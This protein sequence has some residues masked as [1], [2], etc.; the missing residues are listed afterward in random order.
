M[1]ILRLV[2]TALLIWFAVWAESKVAMTILLV[3]IC[4]A[5]EMMA[6]VVKR[7]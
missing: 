6:V 5:N 2:V 7:K 4:L 1:L 3:L